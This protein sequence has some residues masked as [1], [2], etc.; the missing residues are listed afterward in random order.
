MPRKQRDTTNTP[1]LPVQTSLFDEPDTTK[2]PLFVDAYAPRYLVYGGIRM[3]VWR[4]VPTPE[5]P[6]FW[7][8]GEVDGDG[9]GDS[10]GIACAS[11]EDACRVARFW[12]AVK[13]WD[14]VTLDVPKVIEQNDD[15]IYFRYWVRLAIVSNRTIETQALVDRLI[16][17]GVGALHATGGN[18]GHAAK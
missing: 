9:Y 17:D 10:L 14:G 15:R 13:L 5:S 2:R 8:I 11:R 3:L 7:E 6:A 4:T 16:K 1:H 18:D 12:L